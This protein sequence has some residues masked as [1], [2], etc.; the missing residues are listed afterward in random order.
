MTSIIL[1]YIIVALLMYIQL[2]TGFKPDTP[3]A[4]RAAV[5]PIDF[6]RWAIHKI[7]EGIKHRGGQNNA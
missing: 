1:I 2:D 6:V 5:W 3:R 4:L 7:D